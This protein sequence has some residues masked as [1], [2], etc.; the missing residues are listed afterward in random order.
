[1]VTGKNCVIML[2]KHIPNLVFCSNTCMDPFNATI[3]SSHQFSG[4]RPVA[5]TTI[6]ATCSNPSGPI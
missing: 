3:N 2:F 6:W 5:S 1:M 4:F